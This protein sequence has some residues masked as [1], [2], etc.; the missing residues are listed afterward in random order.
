MDI[1]RPER[2]FLHVGE[3]QSTNNDI[4]KMIYSGDRRAPV[5]SA[6]TQSGGRGR[7][8]RS[9]LSP[10]GGLYFSAAYPLSGNEKNIPFLTLAAGL[11]VAES[12]ENMPKTGTPPPPL[13]KWPNDIYI[14]GKK[15]CGILTELVSVGGFPT[16][17]VGIGINIKSLD[18]CPAELADRISSLNDAGIFPDGEKLMQAVVESLDGL[19]YS[20][21]V[22]ENAPE[23]VIDGINRRSFLSGKTVTFS[24]GKNKMQGIAREVGCD[25]SLR[26]ETENGSR[27][28]KF[29]EVT[30]ER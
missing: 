13:I 8:G 15:V 17:V 25:G 11:S 29:G 18:G 16:A 3:T 30:C 19:V 7:L 10:R 2:V 9:F 1:S 4:K 28:V 6:E 21:G 23:S 27:F 24:D 20:C 14:N 22:L 12:I 5:L 26:V